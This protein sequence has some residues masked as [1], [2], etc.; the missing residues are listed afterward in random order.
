MSLV[1]GIMSTKK[2]MVVVRKAIE[3]LINSIRLF[4]CSMFAG[5]C[6]E[7]TIFLVLWEF[8]TGKLN[9]Y[10]QF[11]IH[12]SRPIIIYQFKQIYPSCYAIRLCSNGWF[13]FLFFSG[14]VLSTCII[15]CHCLMRE[16]TPSKT[17]KQTK[18]VLIIN[19]YS[20]WKKFSC[21]K[22]RVQKVHHLPNHISLF[23]LQAIFP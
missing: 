15:V 8:Y 5:P 7:Q 18:R 11:Y 10:N 9:Q 13:T 19:L 4:F 2:T 23:H 12:P 16:K 3:T 21:Y 6:N 20:C 17:G 22:Y 14:V 1:Y